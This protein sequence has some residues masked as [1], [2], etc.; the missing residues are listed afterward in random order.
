MYVDP[1]TYCLSL[2]IMFEMPTSS[3]I[4]MY[5]LLKLIM[6]EPVKV[7]FEEIGGLG[8]DFLCTNC[9]VTMVSVVEIL[10]LAVYWVISIVSAVS[11][12]IFMRSWSKISNLV[13]LKSD[14]GVKVLPGSATMLSWLGIGPSGSYSISLFFAGGWYSMGLIWFSIWAGYRILWVNGIFINE[15]PRVKPI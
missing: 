9:F 10:F 12:I 15:Y 13:I 2:K 14:S 8:D 6:T 5:H 4:K 7:Q 3:S 1:S 11:V